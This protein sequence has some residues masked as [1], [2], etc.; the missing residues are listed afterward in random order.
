MQ[1]EENDTVYADINGDGDVDITDATCILNYYA[2]NM[3][4]LPCTWEDITN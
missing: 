4:G 2:H 3:A 1:N